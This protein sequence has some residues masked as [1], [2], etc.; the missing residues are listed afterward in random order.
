MTVAVQDAAAAL[1]QHGLVVARRRSDRWLQ[2]QQSKIILL[3]R[4]WDRAIVRHL[5][6]IPQKSGITPLGR[7]GFRLCARS[8]WLALIVISYNINQ[9]HCCS[10][11]DKDRCTTEAELKQETPTS[12]V[13]ID[14]WFSVSL[15]VGLWRCRGRPS[16]QEGCNFNNDSCPLVWSYFLSAIRVATLCSRIYWRNKG[17]FRV[18]LRVEL[19]HN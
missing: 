11:E 16:Q 3:C 17:A 7:W 15:A 14:W 18:C 9:S 5:L 10:V 12:R 8:T 1:W 19:Q 4:R 13:E 2:L 6:V